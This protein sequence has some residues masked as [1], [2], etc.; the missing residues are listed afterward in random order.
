MRKL[1]GVGTLAALFLSSIAPAVHAKVEGFATIGLYTVSQGV[2]RYPDANTILTA[3]YGAGIYKSTDSGA[4]FAKASTGLPNDNVN[5]LSRDLA[6]TPVHYASMDGHGV[7]KSTDTGGNWTSINTGLNC[8]YINYVG[9]HPSN[10]NI[11]YAATSCNSTNGGVFR[12]VDGGTNWSL[13]SG[14]TDFGGAPVRRAFPDAST[15][16]TVY[17]AT[18]SK[19]IWR[20]DTSGDAG[21]WVQKGF[22]GAF[23]QTISPQ[24]TTSGVLVASVRGQGLFLSLNGGDTWSDANAGLPDLDFNGGA[25]FDD[26]NANTLYVSFG[27][28]GIYKGTLSAGTITWTLW[29]STLKGTTGIDTPLGI[30]G[31]KYAVGNNGYFKTTDNGVTWTPLQNGLVGSSTNDIQTH[32]TNSNLIYATN[33]DAVWKT[34]DAGLNWTRKQVG[35]VNLRSGLSNQIAIDPADANK[36]WVSSFAEGIY[37]SIDGGDNWTPANTGLPAALIGSDAT[38]SR[39]IDGKLYVGFL[40]SAGYGI[41]RSDDGGATWINKNAT[42]AGSALFVRTITPNPVTASTVYAITGD[43]LYRSLDSGDNWA[44]MANAGTTGTWRDLVV[45]PNNPTNLYMAR[46]SSSETAANAN[47]GVWKSTNNGVNWVQTG[48]NTKLAQRIG[49]VPNSPEPPTLL[50][51]VW[52]LNPTGL[53]VSSDD[54][55]NWTPFNT[56]LGNSIRAFNFFDNGL[57]VAGYGMGAKNYRAHYGADFNASSAADL[58]WRHQYDANYLWLMYGPYVSSVVA[59]NAVLTNN[60]RVGGLGD[61]D[62][63]GRSDI[64][65]Y[66][67]PSASVYI[68][69]MDENGIK[70]NGVV[71][72][73]G[74]GPGWTIEGIGDFNNDGVSDILWRHTSGLVY[75]WYLNSGGSI[76]N[77]VGLGAVDTTWRVAGIGDLNN[78]GAQDVV[79]IYEPG[80]NLSGL[81]YGWLMSQAGGLL[82]VSALGSAP[83]WTIAKVGDFDGDGKS[84]LFWR[85]PAAGANAIWYMNGAVLRQ[86]QLLPAV[87]GGPDWQVA[88]TGDFDSDGLMDIVW[89]YVPSGAVFQWFMNGPNTGPS[90]FATGAVGP[91]WYL[92][93]Q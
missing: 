65:W 64:I 70:N 86:V 35:T 39:G 32:P 15:P 14:A 31:V 92:P 3:L 54:G 91:N 79:W 56:G 58:F 80:G 36:L 26:N 46:S 5:F 12:S 28:R 30:P 23:I 42:L 25:G 33:S 93:G 9:T 29:N 77:V 48:L 73:G 51:A 72:V 60:W 69:L 40:G 78:D 50:A 55:A 75:V 8:G 4:T 84:D 83:G 82:S 89:Y 24:R 11:L 2:N 6:A 1:L 10:F 16:T 88:A 27:N 37:K 63:D 20:S 67:A 19:G 81:A 66:Y 71:Y 17:V 7:Y 43:G 57:R 21:T 62:Q 45:D 18:T 44:K 85:E 38:I 59:L 90:V 68:W 13:V 53:Y 61:V 87:A 52:P 49:L 47:S 76:A 22:P 74:V 41:Y 34:I